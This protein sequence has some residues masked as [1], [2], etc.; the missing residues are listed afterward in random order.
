M[1]AF[2]LRG[3]LE[4]RCVQGRDVEGEKVSV[5]RMGFSGIVFYGVLNVRFSYLEK[6]KTF[7]QVCFLP[8]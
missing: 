1:G 4:M 8:P 2:F 6:M 5:A 7:S 3:V